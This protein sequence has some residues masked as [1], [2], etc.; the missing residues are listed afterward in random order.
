MIID[1]K[2]KSEAKERIEI[3]NILSIKNFGFYY[4]VIE[5]GFTCLETIMKA[6]DKNVQIIIFPV[7]YS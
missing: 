7:S 1:N 4:F 3:E 5:G 2:T 6:F